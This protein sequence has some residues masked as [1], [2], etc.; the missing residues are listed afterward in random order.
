MRYD[1]VNRAVEEEDSR[2]DSSKDEKKTDEKV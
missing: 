2:A 1:K